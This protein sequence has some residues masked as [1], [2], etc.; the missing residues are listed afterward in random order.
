MAKFRIQ[1]HGRLQEW[2]AEEKGYFKDEGLDY[3]FVRGAN[4]QGG[5]GATVQ[6]AD[7]QVMTGAF[8]SMESG[9]ACE[10]SS[11]CHWAINMASSADHGKVIQRSVRRQTYSHLTAERDFS[12]STAHRTSV[13]LPWQKSF[14]SSRVAPV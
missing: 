8:E 11:A 9:R 6:S 7:G 10:V 14:T 3:E 1:P 13:T 2:V 5:R 12:Y 4:Q